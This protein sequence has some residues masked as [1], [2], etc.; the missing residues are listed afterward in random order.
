[1][2]TVCHAFDETADWQH[3]VAAGQL[4]D[5]LS[6]QKFDA[7]LVTIASD[8][9]AELHS[10]PGVL[11]RVSCIAGLNLLTAPLLKRLFEQG[12]DLIHAWGPSAATASASDTQR[13]LVVEMFDPALAV[14]SAKVLRSIARPTAFAVI[15]STQ[16]IRR[17]LIENG[18]PPEAC[19]VIRAG[20]DFAVIQKV[21][22]S[23]LRAELGI[24]EDD[25]VIVLPPRATDL[26]AVY[27]AFWTGAVLNHLDGHYK[28]IVPGSGPEVERLQSFDDALPIASALVAPA[29]SVPFEQLISVADA[30]LLPDPDDAPTTSIAWA[31]GAGAVVIAA[32]T[33]AVTELVVNKVN[34][35]LYKHRYGKSAA[36]RIAALLRERDSHRNVREAAR[37]QAY[38]VFSLRRYVDQH[39][40]V[41][42]NVLAGRP[43]SEG[44][45]DPAQLE[46]VA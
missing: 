15:C 33:Y 20:I 11:H 22:K 7:R 17:R 43:P 24:D 44:V 29:K 16:R 41:Y 26:D 8:S 2:P 31:F 39:V 36:P 21:R 30:L 14:R 32:A 12:V 37:G 3:R 40:Q 25:F 6:A 10:L 4:L 46:P 27:A 18:V 5:R 34:G 28:I 23:R 9:A 19:V 42:E 1:M 38:E 35:L 13:P 45:T